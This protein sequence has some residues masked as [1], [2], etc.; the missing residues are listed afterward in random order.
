MR[1][2]YQVLSTTDVTQ[3]GL[4]YM[5]MSL[6]KQGRQSF[7]ANF[8]SFKSHYGAS[9]V[10]LAEMWH[11]LCSTTIDDAKLM[12]KEKGE[13]GFSSFLM[14]HHFLWTYPKNA[15]VLASRFGVCEKKASGRALWYWVGKVAALRAAKI[16]KSQCHWLA[17]Y[18]GF[19]PAAS[20]LE[21]GVR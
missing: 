11:D 20:S 10:V 7:K 13:K 21:A 8:R 19:S 16:G 4:T 12:D 1:K 2:M 17:C 9:P 14:A 18:H 3:R 5:G 15:G 6:E